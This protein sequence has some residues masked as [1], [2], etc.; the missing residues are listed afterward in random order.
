MRV[1]V[2]DNAFVTFDKSGVHIHSEVF[3]KNFQKK[4]LVMGE[5]V[6][7]E[8]GQISVFIN[9]PPEGKSGTYRSSVGGKYDFYKGDLCLNRF[10]IVTD[11]V[12]TTFSNGL[13]TGS[14]QKNIFT[15]N[16]D[17]SLKA[18]VVP[19]EKDA[20]IYINIIDEIAGNI[21]IKKYESR[22]AN[23]PSDSPWKYQ[24]GF[25]IEVNYKEYGILAFY[26]LPKFYKNTTFEEKISEETTNKIILYMFMAYES[27]NRHDTIFK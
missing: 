11:S 2:P 25:S 5:Y 6:L 21:A 18:K 20:E 19:N 13:S 16:N 8:T 26:P 14:S 1:V 10:E 3:G 12:I 4:A 15:R 7:V 9:V 17:G 27:F 22:S 23:Q 24:T